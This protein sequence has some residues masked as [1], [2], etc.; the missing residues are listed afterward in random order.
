MMS[1]ISS[2]IQILISLVILA[3]TIDNVYK[4]QVIHRATNSMKDELV[5]EVRTAALAKGRL[6][7]QEENKSNS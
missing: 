2:V 3:I 6:D 5:A 4:I 7:A 1:D